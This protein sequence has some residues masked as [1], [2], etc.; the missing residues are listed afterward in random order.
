VLRLPVPRF[1]QFWVMRDGS[2]GKCGTAGNG[3]SATYTLPDPLV[4]SNP[5]LTAKLLI[6]KIVTILGRFIAPV[7]Y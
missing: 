1:G 5:T 4:G 7:S 3:E 2:D 6:I